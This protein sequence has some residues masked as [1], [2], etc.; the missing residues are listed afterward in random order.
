MPFEPG[1]T[2]TLEALNLLAKRWL[3]GEEHGERR[4]PRRGASL[5]FADYRRYTP[6]DEIRYIDWNVYARHG[7]LFVKEFTAEE[8]VHIAIVVDT[9]RSMEFAGKFR[10]AKELAAAFG[11]IG[12]VNFDTVSLYALGATLRPSMK[13]LRGKGAIFELLGA[14]DALRTEGVT[15]WNSA[16]TSPIARLKGRSL[17][18]LVSDFYD[19]QVGPAVNRLL[20]QRHQADLIHIVATEEIEP[21]A[22]G[23]T[24]LVDLE[25]GRERDVP[26]T[27]AVVEQYRRRFQAWCTELEDFATKGELFYARVR[28]DDPLE[29]RVRDLFRHG[30]LLEH[31]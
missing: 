17:V 22:R 14:I 10:A 13:Y 12:L 27:P 6:G 29:K 28:S 9:S 20:A 11:Y 18:L 30:G 1:F 23:R 7:S 2:R 4:T 25:T 5:E 15:D 16:F 24:R 26:L 8:D 3:I 31:R 21:P 19:P